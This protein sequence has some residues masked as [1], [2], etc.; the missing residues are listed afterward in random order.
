MEYTEN[1]ENEVR[2]E[3]C[4]IDKRYIPCYRYRK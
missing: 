3:I 1:D 4:E 2:D